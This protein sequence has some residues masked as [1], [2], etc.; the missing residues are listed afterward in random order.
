MKCNICGGELASGENVCKYCG[1]IMPSEKPVEQPT[2]PL[3]PVRPKPE[4]ASYERDAEVMPQ[5]RVERM[6]YCSK[7]GR[8]LDGVS[9]KCIMCDAAAVGR[10]MSANYQN[11]EEDDMAQKKKKKKK[12]NTVRNFILAT[13]ALIILFAGGIKAAMWIAGSWGILPS[14]EQE[15]EVTE[16]PVVGATQKPKSTWEPTTDPPKKETPKPTEEPT[17]KP[18]K[19][20]VP[21]E[22]G[23]A[24][25]LR[26]GEYEYKSHTHLITVDELDK[27]SRSEIKYIYWEIYARHG[28]TFDAYGE[29][30]DYFENNHQWYM[31][32]TTDMEA[33]EAQFNDI[34]KRNVKTIFDYQKK[35]GWR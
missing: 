27:L 11:T 4:P 24:V 6:S 7:C 17:K 23:D 19:T 28:Y 3:P 33:V 10:G 16:L 32:T 1:N 35:K 21:A 2:R 8:P 29:L 13:L 26:G 15:E 30:A 34:E 9:G 18:K 14:Q 20:P 5:R 31:P 25:E 12:Q 22:K